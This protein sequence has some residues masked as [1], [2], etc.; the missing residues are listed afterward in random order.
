MP[1]EKNQ[2][3]EKKTRNIA[4]GKRLE[5]CLERKGMKAA[6]LSRLKD[7]KGN[8]PAPSISLAIS[9]DRPLNAER[10][11]L[12]AKALGIKVGYLVGDDDFFCNSYEEYEQDTI[13]T[14]AM[15]RLNC[16]FEG[17][18]FTCTGA[19]AF[20]DTIKDYT[21]SNGSK[22]ADIPAE[23]IDN[24]LRFVQ[25]S[26][27]FNISGYVDRYADKDNNIEQLNDGPQNQNNEE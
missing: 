24:F 6:D 21:I 22:T 17:T 2:G 12:F 4:V 13:V 23:E 7:S 9:G 16:L 10:A 3:E 11:A 27:S 1:K 18:A 19:S 5:E 25:Q 20:G 14:H 26:V 15:L 8:I